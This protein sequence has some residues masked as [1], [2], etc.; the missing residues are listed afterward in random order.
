[1]KP[2]VLCSSAVHACQTLELLKLGDQLSPRSGDIADRF[3]N[4]GTVTLINA[5]LELLAR[6][7]DLDHRHDHKITFLR[8]SLR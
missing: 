7:D 2:T 1:V 8:W 3:F 6:P 5:V 4:A